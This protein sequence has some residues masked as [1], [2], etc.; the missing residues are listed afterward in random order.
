MLEGNIFYWFAFV[1]FMNVEFITK[2]QVYPPVKKYEYVIITAAEENLTITIYVINSDN[3]LI[4]VFSIH[5]I[6]HIR[7]LC[8][9][10]FSFIFINTLEF[11][12]Y[13]FSILKFGDQPKQS[14]AN[15]PTITKTYRHSLQL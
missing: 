3:Q 12:Q 2:F 8:F 11:K 13:N 15:Q 9:F 4:R 6:R 1:T 5:D 10:F 14:K 7:I